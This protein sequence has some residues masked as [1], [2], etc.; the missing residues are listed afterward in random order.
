MQPTHIAGFD[1]LRAAM[2]I[3]IVIWH[4]SGAGM[5]SIFS[6]VR[7]HEHVFTL[8][9]FANFHILLLAV[10]VFM[11]MSNFL[12]A[13]GEA[14]PER[15]GRHLKRI[16]ILVTFW[17]IAL[18]IYKNGYA[19][20]SSLAPDSA[21]SLLVTILRAGNTIY[22]F[23]VSL[24][25][26]LLA[27]HAI[28]RLSN[29]LVLLGLI[30]TVFSLALLPQLSKALGYLSL[31]AFWSPLNFAAYPFAGVL[32]ARNLGYARLHSGAIV[33][34][35]L[36]LALLFA[37]YEWRYTV[38]GVFFAGQGYAIPAYTRASLLFS[39]V[40]LVILALDDKIEAGSIVKRMANYALA[41]YC[42]HPFLIAPVRGL[43]GLLMS[44]SVYRS[45]VS[46]ILV[47]TLSYGIARLLRAY[48]LRDGLL[49]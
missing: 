38:D 35:C 5:S 25:L 29:R 9:D 2:S 40:A 15:L 28:A 19:G 10:P 14:S 43:V 37:I 39:A 27:T 11:L 12:Y 1:Y 42:I 41:L 24:L 16:L 13:L 34:T 3:C 4:M 7:Y 26:S 23:F 48:Y 44:A 31:S 6:P 18:I 22:Y 49:I 45:S 36:G 47:I 33:A 32:I 20:L 30:L 46:I 17:P 8:S 21:R